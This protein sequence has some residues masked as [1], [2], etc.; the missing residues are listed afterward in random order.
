LSDG[1]STQKE[2]GHDVLS[3]FPCHVIVPTV[4]CPSPI[5]QIHWLIP[6]SHHMIIGSASSPSILHHHLRHG[7][8][9]PVHSHSHSPT[10]TLQAHHSAPHC[11]TS[12]HHVRPLTLSSPITPSH[13]LISL[14][15]THCFITPLTVA[16]FIRR[17]LC[18]ILAPSS[19]PFTPF[20]PS[21]PVSFRRPSSFSD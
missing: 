5:T 7:P 21:L 10:S 12:H 4:Q 13:P 18:L 6:S 19:S 3:Q 16:V 20:V 14:H 8:S 11:V 2:G 17:D 1:D 9:S 15:S